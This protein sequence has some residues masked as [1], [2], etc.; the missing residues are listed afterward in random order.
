[1]G[2]NGSRKSIGHGMANNEDIAR[3][4]KA[5]RAWIWKRR[6]GIVFA[7]FLAL[8]MAGVLSL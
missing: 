6:A 1:M 5:D 7:V 2:Q 4:H 8:V 3:H